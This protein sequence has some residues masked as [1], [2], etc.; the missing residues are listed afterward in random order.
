[1]AYRYIGKEG[2]GKGGVVLNIAGVMGLEPLPPAPTYSA[3]HHAIVGLSRG[4]G[5]TMHVAKSGVRVV[6]LLAGC[7]RTDLYKNVE[8][9][10]MTDFLGAELHNWVEKAKKQSPDAVGQAAVH[11][12]SCGSSGSVWVV[13]GSRLFGLKIPQWHTFGTLAAQYI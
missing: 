7:T 5:D 10:G 13:E 3:C 1:M 4:F 12:I 2:G 11:A 8:K 6:Q 9:K